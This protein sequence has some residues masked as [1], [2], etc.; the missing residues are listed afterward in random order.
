M[1][2]VRTILLLLRP[3]PPRR[4]ARRLDFTATPS[5]REDHPEGMV[6]PWLD[7]RR[8]PDRLPG[9]DRDAT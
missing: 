2:T 3:R 8:D 4:P 9:R 5:M 1:E 6:Q 7:P